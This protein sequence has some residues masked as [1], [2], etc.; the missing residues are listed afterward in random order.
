[1]ILGF[2]VLSLVRFMADLSL[3][4]LSGLLYCEIRIQT[5]LECAFLIDNQRCLHSMRHF[6]MLS[7][8]VALLS[9][10]ENFQIRQTMYDTLIVKFSNMAM[11]DQAIVNPP[12]SFKLIVCI[13]KLK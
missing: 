6:V 8:N 5:S 7:K 3:G 13:I 9:P 12:A 10:L 11:N 4:A 1:M 2:H